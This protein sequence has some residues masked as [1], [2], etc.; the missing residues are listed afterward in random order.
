MERSDIERKKDEM[1]GLNEDGGGRSTI[2]DYKHPVQRILIE[3][4]LNNFLSGFSPIFPHT[5]FGDMKP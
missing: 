3:P 2:L 1:P 4:T 5:I